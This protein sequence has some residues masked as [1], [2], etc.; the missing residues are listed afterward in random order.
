MLDRFYSNGV[1]YPNSCIYPPCPEDTTQFEHLLVQDPHGNEAN[2]DIIQSI[3]ELKPHHT[4]IF[5]NNESDK[6]KINTT[7][8]KIILKY[9]DDGL[10]TSSGE[11]LNFPLVNYNKISKLK[12]KNVLYSI[13]PDTRNKMLKALHLEF[14]NITDEDPAPNFDSIYTMLSVYSLEDLVVSQNSLQY[15]SGENV[16]SLYYRQG[17]LINDLLF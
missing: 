11:V 3:K 15:P 17:K 14:I 13:V 1:F 12:N 5:V 2:S 16:F 6:Y 4:I 10:H 7:N 9:T 8:L